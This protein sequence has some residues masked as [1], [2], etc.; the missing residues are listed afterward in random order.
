MLLNEEKH[1]K[2]LKVPSMLWWM[3][4]FTVKIQSLLLVVVSKEL[5]G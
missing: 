3:E 1:V 2:K 5:H 4:Y